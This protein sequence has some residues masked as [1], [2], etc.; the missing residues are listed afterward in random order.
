MSIRQI[1]DQMSQWLKAKQGST[2]MSRNL[3]KL[4]ANSAATL[5]K[6]REE[7]TKAFGAKRK[8][9]KSVRSVKSAKSRAVSTK[10]KNQERSEP[11]GSEDQSDQ[12]INIIPQSEQ[13]QSH[14]SRLNIADGPSFSEDSQAVN[15]LTETPGARST[16]N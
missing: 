8:V 12:I 1:Q 2:E 16:T 6:L 10:Q 11:A 4:I 7:E 15:Y 13:K 5:D 9:N 3:K 14:I